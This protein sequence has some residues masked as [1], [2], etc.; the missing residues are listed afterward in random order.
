MQRGP[1]LTLAVVTVLATVL[2]VLDQV[3]ASSTTIPSGATQ[4]TSASGAAAA[5]SDTGSPQAATP[6]I[7][8]PTQAQY[9]G[10]TEG[11]EASIAVTVHNARISAYLCDGKA[12]EGWYQGRALNGVIAAEGRGSNVLRA[13]LSGSTLFGTVTAKGRSWSFSVVPVSSPAGL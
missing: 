13:S 2:L 10:H 7:T 12:I 1:L 6:Q 5:P 11:S 9:T 8:F 4:N 3:R